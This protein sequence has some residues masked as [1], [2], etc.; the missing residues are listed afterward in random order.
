MRKDH[1]EAGGL[2]WGCLPPPVSAHL[3]GEPTTRE[4]G[5]V[6]ICLRGLQVP[7]RP[8]WGHVALTASVYVKSQNSRGL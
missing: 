4:F 5:R 7:A 3:T 1:R 6:G 8:S 2:T